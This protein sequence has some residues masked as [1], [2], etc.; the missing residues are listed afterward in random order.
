MISGGARVSARSVLVGA[1]NTAHGCFIDLQSGALLAPSGVL[2]TANGLIS[3]VGTVTVSTSTFAN[4]GW[5]RPGAPLGQLTVNGNYV[6][7]NGTL[8]LEL[9]GRD[10]GVT[11]DQLACANTFTAGG[12]LKVI[13]RPGFL[14]TT[15]DVFFLVTAASIGNYFAAT[16]LPPWFSW[17]LQFIGGTVLLGVTGVD[18]AT[19]GVPKAWL[20]DYG[21]TN[22][23]DA[24]ATNDAD[25]DHVATWEEYYAGTD[26]TNGASFFQCLEIGRTN[27]PIIGKIIRWNAV[28]GRVYAI[29]ASTNLPAAGWTELTN[30]LAA[31]VNSWTDAVDAA[32]REY[33][34]RVRP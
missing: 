32:N 3:G 31:P 10:A 20:A 2:L 1:S 19:N 24:A 6:Q 7:T 15:N 34:I 11:Y 18:T 8:E 29:D 5:V 13:R 33:R 22:N 9:G 25:G 30:D 14:P 4:D 12:T 16:N 28:T 27:L 21:W 23:F 26:P 17:S